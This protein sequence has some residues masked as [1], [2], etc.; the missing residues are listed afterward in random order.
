MINQFVYKK[1]YYCKLFIERLI[2]EL[3]NFLHQIQ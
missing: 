2:V 3:S 1:Y